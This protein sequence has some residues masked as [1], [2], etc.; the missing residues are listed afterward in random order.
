MNFSFRTIP[1]NGTL[2]SSGTNLTTSNSH[3]LYYESIHFNT[4]IKTATYGLELGLKVCDYDTSMTIFEL[5]R[6]ICYS[7]RAK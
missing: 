2:T 4:W 3:L 7:N 1:T 5:V 6:L